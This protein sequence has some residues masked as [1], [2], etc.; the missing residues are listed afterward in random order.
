MRVASD[1][2][3]PWRCSQG[4]LEWYEVILNL[5]RRYIVDKTGELAKCQVIGL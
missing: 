4:A 2:N 1:V 5:I 3:K